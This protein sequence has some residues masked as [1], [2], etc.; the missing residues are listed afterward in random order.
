MAI[1]I[2]LF[3]KSSF[4]IG[5]GFVIGHM[6]LYTAYAY[7]VRIWLLITRP[8][9]DSSN[10]FRLYVVLGL[11]ITILNV[12]YFNYPVIN[13]HGIVLWNTQLPVAIAIAIMSMSSLLPAAITFIRESFK[14][15]K[16]RKRF[17]LIG[18]SFLAIIIGGPLHDVANTV[19]IYLIADIITISGFLLMFWGVV[20][21]VKSVIIKGA[22]L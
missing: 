13:E 9:F 16:Q 3:S 5:L 21:D 17:L 1:P 2:I 14:Q 7:L 11:A 12:Y 18:L 6:F 10:I 22:E 8:S 20:S 19:I 15:P 4:I